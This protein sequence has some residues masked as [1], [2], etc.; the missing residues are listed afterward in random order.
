M[1]RAQPVTLNTAQCKQLDRTR[2]AAKSPF[3]SPC[4]P[5]LSCWP[6]TVSRIIARVC[7]W[8][9]AG[10][11]A[12]SKAASPAL[13]KTP[14]GPVHLPRSQQTPPARVQRHPEPPMAAAAGVSASTV[15][16]IWRAHGL[17]LKANSDTN[18]PEHALVLSLDEKSQIQA[19]DRT[20]PGAAQKGTRPND[21][22]RLQAQRHDHPVCDGSVIAEA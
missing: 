21:D 3:V 9:P 8:W 1:R 7:S 12:F 5:G 4:E 13:Q 16:R 10:A 22:P 14:H 20:Q 18:P 11:R 19:L 2:A 15:G 6:P 17:E